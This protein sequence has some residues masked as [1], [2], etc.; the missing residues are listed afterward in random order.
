MST[1]STTPELFADPPAAKRTTVARGV[2]LGA[3]LGLAANTLAFAIGKLL[4]PVRVVTGSHPEGADLTYVSVALATVAGITA[5]GA[6][7][8]AFVRRGADRYK[9]WTG[10]AAAVAM[11]SSIPLWRLDIDAASKVMLTTMHLLAG[12]SA[13]AGQ[14]LARRRSPTRLERGGC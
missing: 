2:A 12:A 3:V 9:L 14:H 11:L 13:I 6:L 1:L 7:L 8:W 4:G 10:V 5:G